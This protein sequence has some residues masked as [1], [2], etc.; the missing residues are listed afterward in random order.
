MQESLTV[1]LNGQP[2]TFSGL[3]SPIG[4]TAV[5]EA[6]DLKTD[7]IAV[8]HNGD[9]VARPSWPQVQVKEGD[10]LEIVHFVGGGLQ[11]PLSSPSAG[12]LDFVE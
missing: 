12:L 10:R 1:Q 5:I 2:R 8:E 11:I 4:L 3:H 6:L 7:R 9:I